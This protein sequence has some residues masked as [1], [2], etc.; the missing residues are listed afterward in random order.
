M[1]FWFKSLCFLTTLTLFLKGA[2]LAQPSQLIRASGLFFYTDLEKPSLGPGE[3]A[4]FSYADEG[5]I[6]LKI[7]SEIRERRGKPFALVVDPFCGDGKSGL[8][9]IFYQIAEKLIG[10]DINPRAVYYASINARL[11]LLEAKSCF[12]IRNLLID[13]VIHSTE[14]GNT[15][16]IAN[17]P[18]ALRARGTY[19][20]QMR[21]GGENGLAL[22]L[23]FAKQSLK[24]SS[25]GDVILGIG[26]SRIRKDGCV[27]LEG[28][29]SQL[30]YKY[31][32]RLEMMLLEKEKL[33]RGFNGKKEQDNP[34][35][36]TGEVFALKADPLNQ[37]D[38]NAYYAAAQHHRDA[39][40]DKLGYY[41][42]I[43]YK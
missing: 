21:D 32:G 29:L 26:Y 39:G 37:E 36:I 4:V 15:L 35:P 43:I 2:A 40:F 16:W 31:G 3:S 42:Y 6:L 13:R 41:V 11:N 34:M 9:L 20:E 7:A 19:L 17:P 27:E 23:E 10:S 1:R 18:F 38:L 24:E 22:T 25:Q 12:S 5:A 28:E 30:T 33:W 8:P 14:P